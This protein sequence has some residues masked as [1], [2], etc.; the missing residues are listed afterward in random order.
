MSD[1]E[2]AKKI[3]EDKIDLLIDLKGLTQKN[4]LGIFSYKDYRISQKYWSNKR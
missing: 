1:Y 2:A 3:F 4:R